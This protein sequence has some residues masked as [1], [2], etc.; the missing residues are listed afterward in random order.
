[1]I[2]WSSYAR[3]S[4]SNKQYPYLIGLKNNEG[5]FHA[6]IEGPL[7]FNQYSA[8]H[9]PLLGTQTEMG[10]SGIE[11]HLLKSKNTETEKENTE[12]HALTSKAYACE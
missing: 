9:C 2:H 7:W 4:V 1:M 11:L 8:L 3:A 10:S 12:N 5:F 6:H